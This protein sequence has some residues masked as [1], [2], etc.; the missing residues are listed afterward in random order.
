[1]FKPL[2]DAHELQNPQAQ[3]EKPSR[4]QPSCSH[5]YKKSKRRAEEGETDRIVPN[6]TTPKELQYHPSSLHPNHLPEVPFVM[7]S[8]EHLGTREKGDPLVEEEV[9]QDGEVD[10][11]EGG[12]GTKGGDEGGMV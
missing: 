2:D 5:L 9:G 3:K 8:H 12:K 10:F 6:Q 7:H 4:S 11:G 1:M